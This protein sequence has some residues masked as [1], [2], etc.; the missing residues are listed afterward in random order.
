[1]GVLLSAQL[2]LDRFEAALDHSEDDVR[3][4]LSGDLRARLERVREALSK[5]AGGV[6]ATSAEILP[7]NSRRHPLESA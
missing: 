3:G 1:M 7:I 5:H 6:A 2:P 4:R